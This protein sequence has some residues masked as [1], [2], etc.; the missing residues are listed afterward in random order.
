MTIA[1][2]FTIIFTRTTNTHPLQHLLPTA[3]FNHVLPHPH[4]HYHMSSHILKK[5]STHPLPYDDEDK[6]L[7]LGTN[8]EIRNSRLKVGTLHCM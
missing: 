2:S 8:S 3:K 6:A 1:S 5:R 7:K 4:I